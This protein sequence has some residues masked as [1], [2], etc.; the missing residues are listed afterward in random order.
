[1]VG[2]LDFKFKADIDDI[3]LTPVLVF[4]E[5]NPESCDPYI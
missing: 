4:L 3:V 5:S 2:W 1:M